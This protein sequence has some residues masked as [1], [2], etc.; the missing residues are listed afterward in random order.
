MQSSTFPWLPNLTNEQAYEFL[1]E[2]IQAAG[3]AGTHTAFL[4]ALDERVAHGLS[5]RSHTH[6]RTRSS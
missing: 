3:S 4:R 5:Q 1:G 6:W 2:V